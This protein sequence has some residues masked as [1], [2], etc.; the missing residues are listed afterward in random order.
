MWLRINGRPV[1]A[2]ICAS[3]HCDVTLEETKLKSKHSIS[4]EL[5]KSQP[6]LHVKRLRDM[7]M[8]FLEEFRLKVVLWDSADSLML[9]GD[10]VKLLIIEALVKNAIDDPQF[11]LELAYKLV[12]RH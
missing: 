5:G 2:E 4:C 3:L 7:F 1:K 12:P 9:L 11:A 8:S 10:R 6:K